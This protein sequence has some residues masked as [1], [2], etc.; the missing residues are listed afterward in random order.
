MNPVRTYR[1]FEHK[2]AAF[3]IC[4]T[5]MD[6]V[7]E[8]IVQ[9]RAVLERYIERHPEFGSSFLP[10]G[11]LP[12]APECV[13]RMSAAAHLVGVGPMAAVAGTMAQL[14]AE[15]G[16]A[17]GADEAIIDN[18][19]DIFI[20]SPQPV[21]VGLFGGQGKGVNR[22]AFSIAPEALPLAVCS[23]SGTMGHSTSL[24]DCDLATVVSTDASVADAAATQAANQ[25][26]NT[27]DI[28]GVLNA[29]VAI[30]GV[31]GVL[32]VKDDRVGM[33]GVLPSLCR[34]GA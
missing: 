12:S 7:E 23:S 13:R 21:T 22:L 32:I 4:C 28:D 8:A 5:A 34:P 18:G 15:A 24:G 11:P 14:A 27:D 2:E 1:R 30:Q 31:T 16:L 29:T 9:Q 6:A 33:A 3:R 17:A 20:A 19:G 10:L 25:V 26:R